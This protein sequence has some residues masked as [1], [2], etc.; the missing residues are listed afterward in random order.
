M[1]DRCYNPKNEKYKFYGEIGIK[2]CDEWRSN[3]NK[4]LEWSLTNG[5]KPGLQIDKDIVG[6][7]KLYSPE[8]CKW[9]TRKE[10][11]R[12]RK[13]LLKFEYNGKI[14]N[15][16]DI[17]ERLGLNHRIVAQRMNR[18]KM[19]LIEALARRTGEGVKHF[20]RKQKN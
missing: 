5:W 12:A 19:T 13:H 10:N 18:D 14:E 3:Y 1:L 17:C 16:V 9:V 20:P 15:L 7:S 4:F 6:D 2:V 8:T 11:Q